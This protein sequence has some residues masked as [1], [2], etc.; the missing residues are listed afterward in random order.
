LELPLQDIIT[1][2]QNLDLKAQKQL[3]DR[4]AKLLLSISLKYCNSMADAED[5]VQDSFIEIYHTINS[6]K[7]KGAFEGWMKRIDI[8]KAIT[9]FK[10][11][12]KVVPLDTAKNLYPIAE[13]VIEAEEI[14][15]D[16][17]LQ[18]IQNL[19]PQYRMVF[20]LFELD[21]YN[22]K[23]IAELLGIS[24]GTSKSNLHR[25]KLILKEQIIHYS[26]NRH[27]GAS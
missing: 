5:N 14:E 19:P 24:E 9:K 13:V 26:Q 25:A 6:F 17:V 7:N 10:K 8:N 22:H 18:C 23:E 12:C 2:C 4:Y 27:H 15:M 11:N 20:S 3:F 1:G 16:I 21:N